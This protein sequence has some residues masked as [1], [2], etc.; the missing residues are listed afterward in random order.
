MWLPPAVVALARRLRRGRVGLGALEPSWEAAR[1]K[2]GRYDADVILQ[3]VYRASRAVMKGGPGVMERDG[4]VLERPTLPLPLAACLLRAAFHAG[5]GL[6]VVDFGGALGSSYRQCV[7]F[8]SVIRNVRWYVVEQPN[9]VACGRAEFQTD[10]LRFFPTIAEAAAGGRPDV[11]LFSSVLQYLDDPYDALI[12]AKRLEPRAIIIDRTPVAKIIED[13]F[14]I[15][16]VP[17][18]IFPIRLAFRIFAEGKFAEHLAADYRE[19]TSF[20]AIDADL[21]AGALRVQSRGFL[22]ERRS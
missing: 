4:V 6:T 20:D 22:F 5:D 21:W 12:Q 19:V 2:A 17:E 13:A 18:D 16:H 10:H 8:L 1:A 14:T 15:Q 9:F 7:E 11:I 3:R